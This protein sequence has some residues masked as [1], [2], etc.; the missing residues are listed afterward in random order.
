MTISMSIILQVISTDIVINSKSKPSFT[1][2]VGRLTLRWGMLR[3]TLF[4]A[5]FYLRCKFISSKM[6]STKPGN[7]LRDVKRAAIN[8]HTQ[9]HRLSSE[10]FICDQVISSPSYFHPGVIRPIS[11]EPSSLSYLAVLNFLLFLR[12]CNYQSRIYL[13][14][15]VL[16]QHFFRNDQNVYPNL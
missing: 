8:T 6:E 9:T 14:I 11:K 12:E 5:S 1:S 2:E 7:F 16:Y 4:L 10:V 3:L 13:P 15:S